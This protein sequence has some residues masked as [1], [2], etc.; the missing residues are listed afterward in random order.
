M[1]TTA[2]D[3]KPHIIIMFLYLDINPITATMLLENDQ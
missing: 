3:T 2:E 1:D